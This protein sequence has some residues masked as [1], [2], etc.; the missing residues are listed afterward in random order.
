MS[1]VR[2]STSR[3]ISGPNS[4]SISARVALVSSI[5]SCSSATAMVASSSMRSVRIAATSR[6]CEERVARGAPLVAML[7]HGIDIG[8]LSS[9]SF[10]VGLVALDPLDKLVLAHHA[11]ELGPDARQNSRAS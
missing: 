11:A 8:R 3:P 2:P 1:L 10:D 4:S 6:G 9:A 7:L 5:V